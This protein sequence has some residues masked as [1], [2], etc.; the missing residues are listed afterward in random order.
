MWCNHF[1]QVLCFFVPMQSSFTVHEMDSASE[2]PSPMA[3]AA[4]DKWKFWTCLHCTSC[5]PSIDF[6]TH[7]LCIGCRHQV[8]RLS[9]QVLR[10]QKATLHPLVHLGED[11]TIPLRVRLDVH[12]ARGVILLPTRGVGSRTIHLPMR[13]NRLQV[14]DNGTISRKTRRIFVLLLW[15]SYW[16]TS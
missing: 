5:M 4:S 8:L 9:S 11:P 12:L 15:L 16:T 10:I 13:A 7:T 2:P 1:A 6:D 14:A 3:A